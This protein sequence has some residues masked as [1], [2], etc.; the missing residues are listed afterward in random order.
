MGF[1]GGP[2]DGIDAETKALQHRFTMSLF[3]GA[4]A[5]PAS[6]ALVKEARIGVLL[7]SFCSAIAGFLILRV[8]PLA[9]RHRIEQAGQER[10]ISSKGDVERL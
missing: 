2:P 3:I 5:F 8:A 7:G 4:L 9:S 6:P 10:E 1:A